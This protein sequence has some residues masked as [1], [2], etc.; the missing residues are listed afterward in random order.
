MTKPHRPAGKQKS[1]LPV[2]NRNGG[3]PWSTDIMRVCT[4]DRCTTVL[5]RYNKAAL[6]ASCEAAIP[7]DARP[8]RHKF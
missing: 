3:K 5:S 6:C 1:R 4:G 8:Y 2:Y 7:L